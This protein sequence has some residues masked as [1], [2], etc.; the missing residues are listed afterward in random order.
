MRF[1]S[2][3]SDS[4][5]ETMS[6]VSSSLEKSSA[7]FEGVALSTGRKLENVSVDSGFF[8]FGSVDSAT[9]NKGFASA[10]GGSELIVFHKDT[11]DPLV[12]P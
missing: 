3:V 6:S 10:S 2:W 8:R 4:V 11:R 7:K 12:V 9:G 1:F 5:F